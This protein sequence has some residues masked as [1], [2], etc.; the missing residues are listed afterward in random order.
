MLEFIF[1]AHFSEKGVFRFFF[2][3]FCGYGYEVVIV[4]TRKPS[5]LAFI[6]KKKS[7]DY[8]L[9]LMLAIFF[10]LYICTADL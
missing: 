2:L 7:K 8:A 5:I 4:V 1:F 3:Q 9:R 6:E 10:K